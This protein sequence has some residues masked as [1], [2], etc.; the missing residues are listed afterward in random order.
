MTNS[1][2]SFGT[3]ICISGSIAVGKSTFINKLKSQADLMN[4]SCHVMPELLCPSLNAKLPTNPILFD[5][6]LIAHRLQMCIDSPHIAKNYK[7]L[8]ME[9]CHIDHLAFLLAFDNLG[10]LPK[11]H[12]TWIRN[13][14]KE[15]NP[16]IPDRFVFLELEPELAY[17]RMLKRNEKRDVNFSSSLIS[18][19]IDCY[20]QVIQEYNLESRLLRL[21]WDDFGDRL[22]LSQIISDIGA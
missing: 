9:R 1:S 2:R 4:I 8:I 5:T 14:I 7:L 13:I 18:A 10:F 16:P 20:D 6:F 19:L 17:S 22:S 11:E 3:T 15:I 12:T 21:N